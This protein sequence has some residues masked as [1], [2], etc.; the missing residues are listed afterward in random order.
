MPSKE[1]EGDEI[2]SINLLKKEPQA[3]IKPTKEKLALMI[4][5]CCLKRKNKSVYCLR[6]D[7]WVSERLC[8]ICEG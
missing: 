5:D 2:M 6:L 3:H 4:G 7:Q 1:A 8:G